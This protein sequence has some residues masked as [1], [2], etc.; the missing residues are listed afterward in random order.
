MT[1]FW[2]I[3]LNTLLIILRT[4]HVNCK[5]SNQSDRYDTNYLAIKLNRS[6]GNVL[7]NNLKSRLSREIGF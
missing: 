1:F 3:K 7:P 4:I 5:P 6:L 2:N